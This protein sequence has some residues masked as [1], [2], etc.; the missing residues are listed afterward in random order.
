MKDCCFIQSKVGVPLTILELPNITSVSVWFMVLITDIDIHLY[1]IMVFHV[2]LAINGNVTMVLNYH[3]IH[4]DPPL[5]VY[6]L[7]QLVW[8][9]YYGLVETIIPAA[10]RLSLSYF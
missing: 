6:Q 3:G 7:S 10:T 4:Y 5:W 2:S 9:S 1:I 8:Y